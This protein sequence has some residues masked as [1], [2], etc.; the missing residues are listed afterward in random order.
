VHALVTGAAGFV[1]SH[2]AEALIARGDT[3]LGIDCFT[4]YYDRRVKESNLASLRIAPR[5]EF[6]EAD[7][8]TMDLAAV[9]DGID[10]VFHQAAQA[11]V[12]HSWSTGFNDY[13]GHNVL[14]TQLLLETILTV[15][16]SV[17]VVYASSSSVYGNQDR[18]PTRETDVPAP[19]SPYGVTKLAAEHLCTLYAANWNLHT[20]A[21]RYFTVYGPR[22]RPDMSIYRLCEAALHAEAFPRY[23]DGSQVREF[24]FVDDIVRANLLAADTDIPPGRFMNV[25]GGGEITLNELVALVESLSGEPVKIET[26]AA[27]AGDASRNGGATDVAQ[28]LLRWEPRVGLRD[29]VAAQLAWHRSREQVAS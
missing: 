18:Y 28:V 17:R 23:G 4:P 7:L 2:L 14:A 3:V 10:V 5:F 11:G 27:Q 21:L 16:P 26:R 22:Q 15:R 24:T 20:T 8:R 6:L 25:S 29:G 1:G 12:R 13:V 9:F 19:F